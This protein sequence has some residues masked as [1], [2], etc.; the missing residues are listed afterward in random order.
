MLTAIVGINWGDEGKGRMVDLLS[1]DQ[2]IVVRYQG[3]HS[4]EHT[5]VTEQGRFVLNLLPAGI[6]RPDV[7]CVMGNGMA[8]DPAHLES[9]IA[10]L[11]ERGIL[12][13]PDRL[14]ISDRAPVILPYHIATEQYELKRQGTD[15][16]RSC[17][18]SAVYGDRALNL[19]LRM[20]DLLHPDYLRAR[21]EKVLSYKNAVIRGVY[22]GEPVTVDEVASYALRYGEVFR[23]YICD[24]GIYLSE[25]AAQG[26]NI[27]FEAPQGAL[28][29]VE[30]GVYPYTCSAST[31]AAY[32]TV[33]GG[34]PG[35]K[36][37]HTVGVLKSFSS[38]VGDGPFV[39]ELFG[40]DADHLMETGN[41]A[42]EKISHV[43]RIG[44]FDAVA[45][46]YGVE[47][48]GASELALTKLDTLS[49]LDSIPVC[50]A[51]EID[52]IRTKHFP[53]GADLERAKPV[54]EYV[55]GWK[56]DISECRNPAD[57]PV[58][59]LTYVKYIEHLVGCHISYVSVG[60]ERESF[61][62]L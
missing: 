29:D 8:I 15:A 6:L 43:H 50:V 60:A 10:S 5:I 40:E 17:G 25:A 2:Q 4:S 21:L 13:S 49:Y 14:K 12:V 36:L 22:G 55:E 7:V 57:L 20:G 61:I 56:T 24:T 37:D 59:A 52:G 47:L 23:D 41:E 42:A 51:Y 16:R 9:E 34:V 19:A 35:L 11:L 62:R 28:R 27:L 31:L 26:M 53:V 18:V 58:G 46:R 38:M 48:Q 44:A 30:F 1:G 54:I 33:G 3:D 32:A 45:S 39:S